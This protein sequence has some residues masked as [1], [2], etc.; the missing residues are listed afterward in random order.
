MNLVQ[1]RESHRTWSDH[2]LITCDIRQGDI[3]NEVT[4]MVDSGATGKGFISHSAAQQLGLKYK[5]LE[6]AIELSGFDGKRKLESRVTHVAPLKMNYQGHQESISLYVTNLGK[7]DIILGLPWMKEHRVVLDYETCTLKCTAL[8]CKDHYLRSDAVAEEQI[9]DPSSEELRNKTQTSLDICRIGTAPFY[10]L[11]RK[12]HHEIFAVSMEDIDAALAPKIETE[13]S[14]KLPQELHDLLSTFSKA[15]ANELPDHRNYDHKIDLEPGKKHGYGPLYNMSRDELLVLRKYLDENLI[16]GFIRASKSPVA[17]PVIFVRKPGG[18]LRFCVDYRGLNAVTIKNR[19]PI[20]LIQETLQRLSKAKFFTKL[21]IV[22]AFNRL[23]ISKGD[24]YLTAFRTR[25]GLF[26]YLVMP[27]GLANAPSTFQHYVNDILRPYLDIFC[28][29]YI[30]DILIYSDNIE[31]HKKHVRLVIEA[32]KEAGLQLDIDKCEFYKKEVVYLGLILSTDGIKMDPSKTEAVTAWETPENVRDVRSFIGFANFYRRFIEGFSKIAA[33]MVALTRKDTE[34]RWTPECENAFQLLKVRFTSAPILKHFDPDKEILV[35]P[36]A[37]DYVTA[38]VLSQYSDTGVLHPVAFFSKTMNPA[39][40]NY[41]IYDKELLAIIR[42]FEQWRSELEG[43]AFPIMVLSDHKNLQ[44]FTTTKQLSHRQARWSEYLSRFQFTIKYRPGILTGKPDAL[45]RRSQ[46]QVAKNEAHEARNQTLLRPELFVQPISLLPIQTDRTIQEIIETEYPQDEFIQGIL[47]LIRTGA[48][49]S[50]KI[51]LS[52]CE[53]IDAKLYYKGTLVVPA[54]DELKLKILEEI[55][56]SPM[57]GHPGRARTLE[58]I[59]RHYYWM[60]MHE[61][62]RR[63]VSCCN[64][65]SRVKSSR[66]KHQ[67]LLKPLAVPDCRWRDISVDFIVDLP[68]SKG[69]T[70]I[71]VVVCRLSKMFHAVACDNI[72]APRVAELFLHHIWKLHGLPSTIVSDRGT[73][74][75]SAFWDELTKRLGTKAALSTAFHPQTDG[76]TERMNSV[77]E[78]YLRAYV[79]YLQEDWYEWLPLAEFTSNNSVSS[80][81]GV[82]PFLANSGQ[83]PRM[84]FEPPMGTVRPIYQRS[85]AL[86]ANAFVDK[87]ETI[88]AHLQEEMAWAQAVYTANANRH[89]EPAPAYQVGDEVFLD[90][91][92]IST[93]R[94]AKKLDWKNLGPFKIAKVISSHAYRLDLPESMK[95]HDVFPTS[96]LRP[97]PFATEAMPGQT[98]PPPPPVQV[99]GEDEYLIDRIDDCRFNKRRKVFEYLVKWSGYSNLDSTWEP[100][101]E[102]LQTQAAERFHQQYPDKPKPPQLDLSSTELA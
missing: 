31:E 17:S 40:C 91:R 41:E 72:T 30:D 57:S 4:C 20:P 88:Q 77:I 15:A 23:R 51:S 90:A 21:D 52:E 9:K 7:H 24:E 94:P 71:M 36:D 22:A 6:R 83:H 19:Y 49:K 65:C 67:G 34:F 79:S 50:K 45:T 84:G 16:K 80:T 68:L 61:D 89:R 13:P 55:H 18:G 48:R 96:R 74:F 29:A 100:A 46:D 12:P 97:A 54:T 92:H 28:T 75:T 78:Q 76:Q 10:S 98:R 26:E 44:Y 86:D 66:L 82:S 14:T 95:I 63:Y 60:N 62:V 69:C 73:Q 37:S 8:K 43:A 33:P 32:C 81:T 38:G 39:E 35:E 3:R 101:D 2:I 1:H 87:M 27:F 5:K 102:F 70:N 64:T 25:Y 47:E 42:C 85:Q 93:T 56:D 58:Q 59:S 53:S 99:K 11:A